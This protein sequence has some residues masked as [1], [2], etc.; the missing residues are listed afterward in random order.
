MKHSKL[1]SL[2]ALPLLL[3]FA[4]SARGANVEAEPSSPLPRIRADRSAEHP[5]FDHQP[6]AEVAPAQ[7]DGL[8][9]WFDEARAI[10]A[11]ARQSA[12]ISRK[13]N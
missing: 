5:R 8:A 13:R 6:V 3:S 7:D 10:G 11:Q 2:A 4:A 12:M 1:C 9:R